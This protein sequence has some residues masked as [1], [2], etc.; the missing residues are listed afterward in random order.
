MTE[1]NQEYFEN[2]R[3]PD[4]FGQWLG[5]HVIEIDSTKQTAWVGLKIREDHLSS[6]RRVHGGV[7]AAF[8]DF[9]F[10]CAVFGTL[11]PKD[12][13]STVEIKVNYLKPLDLGD[14]L[15]AH[16]QIVYRGKRLC[17]LQGFLYRNEQ[18]DPVAMATATF[19]VV[20]VKSDE[21]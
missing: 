19:N 3:H 14:D 18:K 21:A 10:G 13:C 16:T 15:K 17:V 20:T 9:A 1:K 2:Y 5:Y 11:G 8:L 4:H 6:A 7:I 12:F